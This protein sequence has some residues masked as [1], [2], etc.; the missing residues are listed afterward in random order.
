M[1]RRYYLMVMLMVCIIVGLGACATMGPTRPPKPADDSGY[2]KLSFA[3]A[4]NP[5]F[6]DEV[7]NKY[8]RFTAKFLGQNTMVLMLPSEYQSGWVSIM[9]EGAVMQQFVVPK[10]KSDIVFEL[11]QGDLVEIFAFVKPLE[12][13]TGLGG[14]QSNVL[15][16]IIE[17]KKAVGDNK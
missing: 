4:I 15:F 9:V 13:R 11:K 2:T 14:K 10:D 3:K 8:I 12:M 1:K 6:V 7:A 16:E 5:A 17:M